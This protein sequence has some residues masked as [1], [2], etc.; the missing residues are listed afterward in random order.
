MSGTP[1]NARQWADADVY[2]AFSLAAPNP[3]TI[4]DPF[5]AEWDLVG[6]LDG[7]AGFTEAR[8]EDTTDHF[9]WGGL[10]IRTSRRNYVQ[11]HAFTALEGSNPVVDRL[12]YPGSTDDQIVVPS[13][14]RIE[15]VKLALETIDGAITRRFITANHAEIMVSG[16]VTENESSI[17]A[18]P[19]IAKVFPTAA[20][21]LFVR[22]TVEVLSA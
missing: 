1:A 21:V 9:A 18:V 16:D 22:Q 10:L 5:G 2:V 6:L 14:N 11:T 17:G 12:R 15:Q 19:F 20:G 13:G 4:E 8:S 7:D 3:A